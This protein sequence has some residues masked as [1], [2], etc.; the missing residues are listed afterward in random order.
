MKKI[1]LLALISSM[2][3]VNSASAADLTVSAA[4]S[5]KEA[6]QEIK[7]LF[8][9]NHKDIAVQFNFGASGDL[10]RQIDGGAPVDV[11]AS[12]SQKEMD[13]LQQKG[14]II[15][16]TRR[17]FAG[18]GIVMIYASHLKDG[19][20]S[21]EGLADEKVG[22]IAIGNPATVPAGRYAMEVLEY[23]KL[24]PA[25]QGKLIYAE[26]VRQVLDYVTMG[27]VDAGLVFK[28]ETAGR[29]LNVGVTAPK[30]SHKKALYPVA[31][32]RDAA[33]TSAAKEFVA[34][35]FTPEGKAI[36]QK[37]GFDANI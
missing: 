22:K 16:D 24:M 25:L 26:N 27:E 8:E 4:M 6:F 18:N 1:F 5:L 28:S 35:L 19:L 32:V 33:A 23:F 10:K 36:L 21:I 14:K 29:N 34:A 15:S 31:V 9:A 30:E 12:A 37:Y 13:E 7:V 20:S 3:I 17:N 2:I 11:F